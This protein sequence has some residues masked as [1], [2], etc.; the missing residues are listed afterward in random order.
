MGP[1]ESAA[2][3]FFVT[4]VGLGLLVALVAT[5]VTGLTWIALRRRGPNRSRTSASG[6]PAGRVFLLLLAFCIPAG[7][8]AVIFFPHP[9]PAS[10]HLIA[11]VEVPLRTPTD[12]ADLLAILRRRAAENG[13]HVDDGT[14]QWIKFRRGAH[15]DETPWARSVLTKTIYAEVY[16]GA[17]DGNPEIGVDDGGHQGRA[18][19]T[20][21]RGMRPDLANKT[22]VQL[23]SDLKR[24]WPD[25]RDVPILPGGALP[26]AEDL[27]W[28]GTSYS[29]KTGTSS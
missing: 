17:D 28:T 3:A 19:L 29:V 14:E 20:F 2:V 25:A 15:P 8:T 16:R 9:Q 6:F 7:C 5:C 1:I 22:R 12:H 27:S 10:L 21:S 13:M 23:M 24:R 18:W 4:G 26:L 11:A